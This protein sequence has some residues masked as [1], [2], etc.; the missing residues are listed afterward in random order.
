MLL[1]TPTNQVLLHSGPFRVPIGQGVDR[2]D[3]RRIAA[4]YN[5]LPDLGRYNMMEFENQT[6]DDGKWV[7]QQAELQLK[8]I[9]DEY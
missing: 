5:R 6:G 1:I 7:E 8:Q 9:E 4:A 2:L 3:A